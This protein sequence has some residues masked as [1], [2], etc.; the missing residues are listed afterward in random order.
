MAQKKSFTND[1]KV[2]E[3]LK[4]AGVSYD[5]KKA[6]E[7]IALN[8]R[9]RKCGR[10]LSSLERV[11]FEDKCRDCMVEESKKARDKFVRKYIIISFFFIV[12]LVFGGYCANVGTNAWRITGVVISALVT[13]VSVGY[14]LYT[15]MDK[16]MPNAQPKAQVWGV[17][18]LALAVAAMIA[19]LTYF[20]KS[21]I[22]Y[23]VL[24]L[25]VLVYV[26]YVAYKEFSGLKEKENLLRV[27]ER[28]SR[29]KEFVEDI[30]EAIKERSLKDENDSVN[31][32]SVENTDFRPPEPQ[33]ENFAVSKSAD[34]NPEPFRNNGGEDAQT[35]EYNEKEPVNDG[36]PAAEESEDSG[37]FSI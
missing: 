24:M 19:V 18:V 33:A 8:T 15:N 1:E 3:I 34:V 13:G 30:T 36:I 16:I 25:I 11:V 26:V 31:S 14:V 4:R 28:K 12:A 35:P 7:Q 2:A 22:L 5:P 29:D 23:V 9:C 27:Y 21:W 37:D 10:T 17:F 32:V 20:S 6:R